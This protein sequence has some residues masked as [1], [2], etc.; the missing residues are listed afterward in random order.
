MPQFSAKGG[1][2]YEA[3]NGITAS[4]FESYSG[5][6]NSFSSVLNPHPDAYHLVSSHV[7]YDLTKYLPAQSSTAL[8]FYVHGDNLANQQVWLP[9]WG[10]GLRE[11]IPFLRGRTVYFGLEFTVKPGR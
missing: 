11:T 10:G 6:L 5:P 3:Y 7:R 2:S 8:A 9:D 1:V 4:V